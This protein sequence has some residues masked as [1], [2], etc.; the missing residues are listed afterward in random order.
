MEHNTDKVVKNP[1]CRLRIN[2]LFYK[3]GR[4]FELGTTENKSRAR[5]E[6]GAAE[7]QVQRSPW[8]S[9]YFYFIFYFIS[10]AYY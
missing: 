10:F 4:Q 5:L 2:W 3:R 8:Q 1:N 6:L 9:F 7:L